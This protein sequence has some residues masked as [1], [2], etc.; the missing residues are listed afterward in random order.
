VLVKTVLFLFNAALAIAILDLNS[1]V[2][3]PLF[4]SKLYIAVKTKSFKTWVLIN[5][6]I[7]EETKGTQNQKDEELNTAVHIQL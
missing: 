1:Q 5:V 6:T 7:P 2:H 4:V 3:L